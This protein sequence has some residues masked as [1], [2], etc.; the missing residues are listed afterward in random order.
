V[1]LPRRLVNLLLILVL[2]TP[3]A[4]A[5]GGSDVRAEAEGMDEAADVGLDSLADEGD[6]DDVDDSDP[7]DSGE[8][9]LSPDSKASSPPQPPLRWTPRPAGEFVYG[10]LVANPSANAR[11]AKAA[12]FTHMWSFVRWSQIEPSK[13][14]FLFNS[15]NR[16]RQTTANDLTNVINAARKAG[17]KLVFRIVDPPDWAG[18]AVYQLNPTHLEEYVH[19]VVS[20]GS[21]TIEFI[22]VFNEMNLPRE[23]GTSPTDPAAYVRLL[24]AAHRGAKGADPNV[25]VVSGAVS[26]R[27]GGYGGTMEDVDWLDGLY[28]AGGRDYFDLL[29]IHPYVGNLG[30]EADPSCTP[31]CFRTVE[32]WRAV[33]EKHGDGGKKA[34][35]TETGTLEH[36]SSDLG[37][38]NW[39]KLPSNQRAEYLVKALQLANA[40]YP[41]IAGAMVFNLDYATTPWNPPSSEHHWFSLLNADRSPRQAYSAFQQARQNGTLP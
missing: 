32:L 35:V 22:E 25:K 9:E 3:G 24:Q 7:P 10:A 14:N 8:A 6:S 17:L 12:G 19:E 16:W 4:L 34:F 28:R 18:G 37:P 27:T 31:M 23:W 21:G 38:F 30:P 1:L 33:M 26:A 15:R 41:W 40:N 2:V 29:G 11:L 20:Y 36:T 5:T 13:G 39:M